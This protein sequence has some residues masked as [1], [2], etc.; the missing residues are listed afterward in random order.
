M[1]T[2]ILYTTEKGD[3][4]IGDFISSL[5]KKE[6]AKALREIDLLE[7]NGIYLNFPHSSGIEGYKG[8]RE[9]RIRFSSDNI[10]I[11]YF[12]DIKDTFVLL[13]GF[14]KKAQKLPKKQLEI[15]ITRM[16]DYLKRR[17]D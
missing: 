10:R 12:L 7:Q 14:R 3:S 17:G 2:V 1:W 8:L 4:P 6:E 16:K 13:H 9:L 11:I 15:A 5:P